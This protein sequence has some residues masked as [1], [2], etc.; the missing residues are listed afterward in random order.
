[1]MGFSV[2]AK[3]NCECDFRYGPNYDLSEGSPILASGIDMGMEVAKLFACVNPTTRIAIGV[4]SALYNLYGGVNNYVDKFDNLRIKSLGDT[5]VNYELL[6]KKQHLAITVNGD[7]Q[8]FGVVHSANDMKR[9]KQALAATFDKRYSTQR[10]GEVVYT[11]FIGAN[12]IDHIYQIVWKYI[13]TARLCR[14][15]KH[16][17]TITLAL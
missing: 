15:R 1:M 3:A 14:Y 17:L 2:V 5:I 8:F 7:G 11:R 16:R 9:L 10:N 4:S 12:V 13:G 6:R